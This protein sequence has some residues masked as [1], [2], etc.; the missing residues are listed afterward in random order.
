M[1]VFLLCCQTSLL[2]S[3]LEHQP[4]CMHQTSYNHS[5]HQIWLYYCTQR[6][7]ARRSFSMHLQQS[8]NPFPYL[9][10][11]QQQKYIIFKFIWLLVVPINKLYSVK[12][13]KIQTIWLTWIAIL[14][15]PLQIN[16][17]IYQNRWYF[18]CLSTFLSDLLFLLAFWLRI[19]N[20]W[21]FYCNKA[22]INNIIREITSN[23]QRRSI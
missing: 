15:E 22:D 12:T 8:Q 5:L 10:N 4:M 2:W 19:H 9:Y 23:K 3:L 18:T 21:V 13:N 11:I 14:W 7:K 17:I 16:Y 6:A 1:I 20:W